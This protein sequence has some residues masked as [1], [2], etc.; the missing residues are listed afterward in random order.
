[1]RKKIILSGLLM[2]A[3]VTFINAQSREDVARILRETNT[4]ELEKIAQE[5]EQQFTKEKSEALEFAKK[6][7]IPVIV[8]GK[9]GSMSEL[10][11]IKDD[12]G[13]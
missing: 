2:V 11:M 3:G 6:N 5:S 10:M 12:K 8:Y 13:W 9:D 1:M 7:N 4:S